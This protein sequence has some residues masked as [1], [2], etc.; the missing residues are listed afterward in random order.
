[1]H[2]FAT[3]NF[4]QIHCGFLAWAYRLRQQ[5]VLSLL[6]A[7]LVTHDLIFLAVLLWSLIGTFGRRQ[8]QK[9]FEDATYAL[10]VGELS[11]IVDTESGVHII[12]RT[13]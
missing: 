11:D 1:M 6:I 2:L 8:M 9:P 3:L 13:A 5:H 7:A 4:A 12:V 10:K